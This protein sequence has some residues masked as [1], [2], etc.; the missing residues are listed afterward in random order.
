MII[1]FFSERVIN[2]CFQSW[3][4][5][6][7]CSCVSV[8]QA[9]HQNACLALLEILLQVNV[10]VWNL[11]KSICWH[12]YLRNCRGWIAV[13][14]TLEKWLLI[15]DSWYHL[16]FWIHL[17]QIKL[18]WLIMYY[19]E[20]NVWGCLFVLT[21]YWQLFILWYFIKYCTVLKICVPPSSR[22]LVRVPN[23]KKRNIRLNLWESWDCVYLTNQ[24][25]I[26]GWEVKIIIQNC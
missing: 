10:H 16:Y 15:S 14:S 6:L 13:L 12:S 21:K 11:P 18:A 17:G 24:T 26:C 20:L 2:R 19:I 8:L 5:W 9:V 3:Q 1:H 22:A 25:T 7:K 23:K 4:W